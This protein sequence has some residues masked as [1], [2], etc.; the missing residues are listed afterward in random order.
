M[1]LERDAEGRKE[2]CRRHRRLNDH[3]FHPFG[4]GKQAG[5]NCPKSSVIKLCTKT[6]LALPPG[7]KVGEEKPL[8]LIVTSFSE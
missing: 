5:I 4:S 1:A 3:P 7:D 6:S 8:S 2:G